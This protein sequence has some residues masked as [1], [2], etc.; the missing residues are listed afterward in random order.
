MHDATYNKC[1]LLYTCNSEYNVLFNIRCI[2]VG[3][4][5]L[6][7]L[8]ITRLLR[9]QWENRLDYFEISNKAIKRL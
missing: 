6:N 9:S 1:I 7:A 2:D 3:K 8:Q 5:V 4:I